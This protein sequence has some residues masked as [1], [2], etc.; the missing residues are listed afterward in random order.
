MT[1]WVGSWLGLPSVMNSPWLVSCMKVSSSLWHFVMLCSI[2]AEM[3]LEWS[4]INL[5]FNTLLKLSH[6]LPKFICPFLWR[7]GLLCLSVISHLLFKSI[8]I[9]TMDLA[10]GDTWYLAVKTP[11]GPLSLEHTFG[12]KRNKAKNLQAMKMRMRYSRCRRVL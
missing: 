9:T 2:A 4:V 11:K 10:N 5:A 8:S 6:F 7:D 1:S 3:K 12:W